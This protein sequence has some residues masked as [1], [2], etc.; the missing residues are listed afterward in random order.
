MCSKVMP[1]F[2]CR[3]RRGWIAKCA[4][5]LDVI[6]D[7]IKTR[8]ND[9]APRDRD[10]RIAQYELA[11]ECKSRCPRSWISER[12]Q[13]MLADYGAALGRQ[14]PPIIVMARA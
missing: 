2:T 8:K 13:E 9:L 11:I 7:L 6:R 4:A 5:V 14:L 1:V 3:T 10:I 12:I